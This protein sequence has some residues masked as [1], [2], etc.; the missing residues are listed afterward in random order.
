MTRILKEDAL[1][2]IAMSCGLSAYIAF[3]MFRQ[4]RDERKE[5]EKALGIDVR[6]KVYGHS[7]IPEKECCS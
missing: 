7:C 6:R 2:I 1:A 3:D 4:A 5:L